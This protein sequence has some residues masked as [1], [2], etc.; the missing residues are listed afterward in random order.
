MPRCPCTARDHDPNRFFGSFC[1]DGPAKPTAIAREA[2]RPS[3]CCW[4]WTRAWR[5]GGASDAPYCTKSSAGVD[6]V[7]EMTTS[8]LW[9]PHSYFDHGCS[10]GR[11][12]SSCT[13]RSPCQ[14]A[15][16]AGIEGLAIKPAHWPAKSATESVPG[17]SSKLAPCHCSLRTRSHHTHT[18]TH[19]TPTRLHSAP[20]PCSFPKC[21]VYVKQEP[22][23]PPS[24]VPPRLPPRSSL[25][26]CGLP[27]RNVAA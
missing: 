19:S 2:T 3:N 17:D 5:P 1:G 15:Q 13:R 4:A 6:T 12:C 26:V 23:S 11:G 9:V 27:L 24:A 25:C 7:G 20:L 14:P 21:A 16:C 10:R 8:A 18:L 22:V